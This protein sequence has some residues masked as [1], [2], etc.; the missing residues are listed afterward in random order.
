MTDPARFAAAANQLFAPWA[1]DGP[2][3]V[4]AVTRDGEQ[5]WSG[6]FGLANIN[7]DVPMDRRTILRIGSQTKQFTV[8][9]ILMLEAE[10]KLSLDD[11]IQDHLP[12]VPRFDQPVT[13]RQLAANTSGIRDFLEAMIFAGRPLGAPAQRQTAR[14]TIAR[15]DGLNFAPGTAMLY[16]NTGFLLLSDV[17]EKI[18]GAPYDTVLRRRITGP[19]GMADTSLMLHDSHV[20]KRLAAHYTRQGAVWSHL[21]WGLE[22]GGEG[23]MVSTLDDMLIWTRALETPPDW[24]AEPLARMARPQVYANGTTGIY[25]LGLV[26]DRYNG[27][28]VVGH[29]GSVAGGRSES[30]RF[31]EDGLAVVIIANNDQ[32]GPFS[33]ARRLADLYFGEPSPD[34][35]I[36]AN[37][38]LYREDGGADLFA[39]TQTGGRRAFMVCAG[40]VPLNQVAPGEFRPERGV[41]DMALRAADADTLTGSFCGR[42]VT[43][44]RLPPC[45]RAARPLAGRYVNAA[46]GLEVTITGDDRSARFHLRS[47]IGALSAQAVPIAPDLWQMLAPE[48]PAVGGQPA[49]K[50]TLT[51]T[52]GGFVLN[53][54]RT[55]NLTFTAT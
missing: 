7:F 52:D 23:G 31:I 32:I 22:L 29:G 24:L 38:G 14:D 49:W 30:T 10:G 9:M 39:I 53:S 37:P 51:V 34:A 43:Y 17:I 12:F 3:V 5:V 33:M 28:T 8:L 1:G 16:S 11:A 6:A 48:M 20:Q 25:G 41:T 46:Q 44:R 42:P 15:M 18:E 26:S 47:D 54:E 27:R 19:L 40:S 45:D 36:A 2:G 50:A 35:D 55:R 13:L 21:G 4:A